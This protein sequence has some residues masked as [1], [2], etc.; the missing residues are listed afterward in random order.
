MSL[1]TIARLAGVSRSTVS[2][3]V[4]DDPRVRP[5]VRERVLTVI[6]EQDFHP[7]A[8]ARSLASRKTRIIGLL[9]P[10]A[11][12][13]IFSDP[14]F[15]TLIQGVTDACNAD[16]LNV[17][18]M[19]DPS[20]DPATIDRLY[21]RVIRGRHI[22]GLVIG[23]SMIDDPLVA[24]MRDDRFPTVVIGRCPDEPMLS[25]VDIDNRE[26]A[27]SVVEHLIAHGHRRIGLIG[28]PRSVIAA[29][30]RFDGYHDALSAAGIVGDPDMVV[31]SDFTQAGGAAAMRHLLAVTAGPPDA[32][33]AASDTM[34]AGAFTVL[35][36]IGARVPNDIALIGFDGL[37]RHL[38]TYPTLSTMAQP[39]TGLA[40]A[41]VAMLRRQIDAPDAPPAHH[42]LP[43]F[44]WRR[45]S[46]GCSGPAPPGSIRHPP[47]T[48][49]T[50]DV[51]R[52]PPSHAE[53]GGEP[54]HDHPARP[55]PV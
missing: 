23:T 44:L 36:E 43:T 34:A 2:R 31:D 19:M 42:V 22:D 39:I 55:A 28:G 41:A 49:T 5:A 38:H 50:I 10:G 9:I 45:G 35:A 20:D 27:R 30:N 13:F 32:V 16:D 33:F 3:V 53:K 15:P 6:S 8:A 1:E 18:L 47:G 17:M 46:C 21:R 48:A 54:V 51:A 12:S 7:N 25:W 52:Y 29:Q 11:V 4:N 37:E 40:R 26:A 24:R 14:Y